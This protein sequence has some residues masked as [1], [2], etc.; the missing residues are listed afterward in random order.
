MMMFIIN[1]RTAVVSYDES[2]T[3]AM[4]GSKT[5]FYKLPASVMLRHSLRGF[6]IELCGLAAAGAAARCT[7]TYSTIGCSFP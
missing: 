7:A 1:P 3:A 4:T 2:I 6:E 5:S